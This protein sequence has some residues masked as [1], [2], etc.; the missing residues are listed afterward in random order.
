MT[1]PKKETNRF[2]I[3]DEAKVIK[4]LKDILSEEEQARSDKAFQFIENFV[5]D[6]CKE[7][8]DKEEFFSQLAEYEDAQIELEKFC[9][10]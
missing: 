7:E 6:Y 10:Q 2:D 9:N 1:K 8:K 3:K 4:A 5:N